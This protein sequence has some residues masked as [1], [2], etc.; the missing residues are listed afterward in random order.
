LD[1]EILKIIN[2]FA[3]VD[4][5][6]KAKLTEPPKTAIIAPNGQPHNDSPSSNSSGHPNDSTGSIS[7]I[8]PN[9]QKQL[10]LSSSRNMG[11]SIR[12]V[13]KSFTML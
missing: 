10:K 9:L 7:P 11:K 13:I 6:E 8:S 3:L 2:Y 5:C 12:F 4:E 1:V